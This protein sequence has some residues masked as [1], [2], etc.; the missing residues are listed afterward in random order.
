MNNEKTLVAFKAITDFVN[1]ISEEY[2]KKLK[3]L[4][5]YAR[6]LKKTTFSHET[7][8]NKH[9]SLFRD[10]CFTNRDFIF[11]KNINDLKNEN[12]KYS[13]NVYLNIKNIYNICSSEDKEILLSHLLNIS[14]ILDPAGKAKEILKKNYEE[15]NDTESNFLTEI[16]S[17]VEKTVDPN[18]NP[19]EAITTMMSSGVFTD[20]M[21]GMKTQMEEGKL[22]INKML[23]MVQG[24][25]SNNM[26]NNENSDQKA[27]D[28]M[29]MLSSVTGMLNNKIEVL[30]DKNKKD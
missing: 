24:M 6:L 22:D 10:F 30:E 27:P 13:D 8:I 19:M 23:G 12:I 26:N 20:L 3:N 25:I 4:K 11:S 28:L 17:K 7:A 14:A 21:S 16:I 9:V 18:A 1:A 2:G 5:L 29:G 15:K